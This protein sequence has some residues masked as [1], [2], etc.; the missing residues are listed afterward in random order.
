M[1][2]KIKTFIQ[3]SRKEFKLVNWPSRKETTRYTIFVI[4]LSV[5]LA[6]FLG[7]LDFIFIKIIEGFVI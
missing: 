1:W 6:L 4:G 2:Q 3:E 5:G 7:F